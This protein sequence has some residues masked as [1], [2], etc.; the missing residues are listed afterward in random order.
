MFVRVRGVLGRL[1][2]RIRQRLTRDDP[3]PAD[4]SEV[5]D[6]EGYS[7]DRKRFAQMHF[8]A[9]KEYVPKPYPGCLTLFR[10]HQQD[11]RDID[12]TLGWGRI[13]AKVEIIPIPGN[14]ADI[15][16]AGNAN[17]KAQEHRMFVAMRVRIDD[18]FH[19]LGFRV[20]PEPPVEVEAAWVAIQFEP[21]ASLGAGINHRLLVHGVRIAIQQQPARKVAEQV[22]ELVLR[23]AN[24]PLGVL[25]CDRTEWTVPV[26]RAS[27][28]E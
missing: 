12:P 20:R 14:H 23:R 10:A 3:R 11:L 13:A 16:E 27:G 6:M 5:I 17:A 18:T 24:Q 15:L 25:R 28:S 21:R 2:N 7:D 26:S 9:L 22:D 8:R 4:V 1:A 19:A